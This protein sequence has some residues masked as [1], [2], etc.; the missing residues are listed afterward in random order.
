MNIEEIH[1]EQKNKNEI[2]FSRLVRTAQLAVGASIS[3]IISLS[4]LS[5]VTDKPVELSLIFLRL[6]KIHK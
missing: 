3:F 1:L 5:D 2:A 4:Y 6:N